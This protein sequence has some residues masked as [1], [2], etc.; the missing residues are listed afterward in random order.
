MDW[1]AFKD[2]F[3]PSWHR[4][5]Q[6]AVEADWFERIYSQLKQDGKK[7]R[8]LPA[9][10]D[11]F[12]SFKEC[13]Y[14]NIKAVIILSD[15]YPWV[16]KKQIIA[17]GIP[18]SC[19]YT[20]EPQPSLT[21]FYD[22]IDKEYEEECFREMDLSFLLHQGVFMINTALTVKE[23]K[24]GSHTDLWLPFMQYLFEDV[25]SPYNTGLV[26]WMMGKEA[27]RVERWINPLG[28]YVL[29]SEHPAAAAHKQTDWDTRGNFKRTNKLL[30]GSGFTPIIWDRNKEQ[31][32]VDD[33]P[34]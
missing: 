30:E 3:D 11:T 12:R 17:D 18:I 8:I 24:V 1:E 29:Y 22:G 10:K 9:S 21:K 19:S 34:F 27:K 20:M 7:E 5:M 23:N 31:Q 14:D 6:Q 26:Y 16:K 28:N 33:L 32:L 13:K 25:L 2:R 15:P 4:F